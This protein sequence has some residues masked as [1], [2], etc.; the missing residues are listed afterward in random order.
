MRSGDL[1]SW[2]ASG[3]NECWKA[4]VRWSQN[5]KANSI[6]RKCEMV[7]KIKTNRSPHR[8]YR[9]WGNELAK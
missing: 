9:G 7:R 1:L 8:D 6:N 3:E 5:K 2:V 4:N